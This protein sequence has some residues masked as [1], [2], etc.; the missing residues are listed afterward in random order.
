MNSK[1]HSGLLNLT[2][3]R[4]TDMEE[5]LINNFP[6]QVPGVGPSGVRNTG[7]EF[8][9]DTSIESEHEER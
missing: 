2:L 4:D 3:L 7:L 5:I 8:K 6:T 9:R 1:P